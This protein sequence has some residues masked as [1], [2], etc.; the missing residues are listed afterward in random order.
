MIRYRFTVH[1][2]IITIFQYW[3][4]INMDQKKLNSIKYTHSKYIQER[5]N[6]SF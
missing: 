3:K 5:N 2:D 6:T 4:T 1:E